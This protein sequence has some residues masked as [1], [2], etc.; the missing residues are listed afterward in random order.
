MS[1]S[2]SSKV[3]WKNIKLWKNITI[4]L[5]FLWLIG[6]I[7][8]FIKPD[9]KQF[10]SIGELGDYFGGGL[11][12]LAIVMIIIT[13]MLQADQ[14]EMQT[15]KIE[16]QSSEL[17]ESGVL[18]SYELFKPELE[19]LSVR[20]VSKLMKSSLI[21]T[22][23]N[24]NE[25]YEKYKYDKTVF[26]REIKKIIDINNKK[27]LGKDEELNTAIS[28]YKTLCRKLEISLEDASPEDDFS[29]AMRSTEIFKCYKELKDLPSPPN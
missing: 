11:G 14:L 5:V 27:I 4:G 13:T 3:N 7:Y 21:E 2:D 23:D 19:G 26:L 18:R 16:S 6:G 25:L 29:K 22:T 24:F 1:F 20:I 8:L 9:H 10:W 17:K 15:K 28:D 12:G